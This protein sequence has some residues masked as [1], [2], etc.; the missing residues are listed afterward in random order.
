MAEVAYFVTLPFVMADDG[1]AA[2]E[3]IECFN[4][5]AAAMRAGVLSRRGAGRPLSG[6]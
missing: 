2:G 5:N 4:P 1:V 3:P 6:P